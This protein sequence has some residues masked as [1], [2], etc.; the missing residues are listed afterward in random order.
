MSRASLPPSRPAR[1]GESLHARP[2]LTGPD[3]PA[4]HLQV[5]AMFAPWDPG[6]HRSP[7]A[8]S[9]LSRF[10]RE[11]R[12]KSQADGLSTALRQAAAGRVETGLVL[13]SSGG[14]PR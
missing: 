8:R 6:L 7:M 10:A 1:P 14:I 4:S 11:S 3:P 13:R 9:E 5:H 12:T 2:L